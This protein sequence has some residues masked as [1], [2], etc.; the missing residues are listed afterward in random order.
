MIDEEKKRGISNLFL[1]HSPIVKAANSFSSGCW[2]SF[3]LR[4]TLEPSSLLHTTNNSTHIPLLLFISSCSWNIRLLLT[5]GARSSSLTLLSS[6]SRAG[7]NQYFH[8]WPRPWSA[9]PKAQQDCLLI[10][11]PPNSLS[12]QTS[13]CVIL[14]SICLPWNTND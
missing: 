9:K 3:G 4:R 2:F 12:H 6:S 7:N 10:V 14:L 11:W 8:A 5:T 1:P 13:R